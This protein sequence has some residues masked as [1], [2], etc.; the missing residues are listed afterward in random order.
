MNSKAI[1][2]NQIF[3][4]LESYGERSL[5][6]KMTSEFATELSGGSGWAE[7]G[8]MLTSVQSYRPTLAAGVYS[9][10]RDN[11]GNVYLIPE[12]VISDELI[13]LPGSKIQTILSEFKTFWSLEDTFSTNGF[14]HKRGFFLVGPAG[15][16]KTSIIQLLA[17]D[18]IQDDGIVLYLEDPGLAYSA[19]RMIRSVE[20]KRKL[21]CILEDLDSLIKHYEEAEFLSLF[22]GEKSIEHVVF[23][24]TT[25]YPEEI[26]KRFLDRPSRFDQVITVGLPEEADRL[27]FFE[28]R[29]KGIDPKELQRWA[30]ETQ[31]FGIAHLKEVI[32]SVQC[33]GYSFEDTLKRL[34]EQK[35]T[36]SSEKMSK[37]DVGFK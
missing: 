36:L 34:K 33:F 30:K 20:P 28:N 6:K 4:T 19:L 22:D 31:G 14:V 2:L 32:I 29:T 10:A 11:N 16:G 23:I 7:K 37:K 35:K 1:V 18:L 13:V 24:A 3:Q 12:R 15:S 9:P 17:K 8:G 26:D 25:N 5:I 27:R 21:V